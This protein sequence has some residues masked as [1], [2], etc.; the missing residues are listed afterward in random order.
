VIWNANR[1]ASG[2]YFVTITA[3]EYVGTQKMMLIK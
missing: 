3:D 2:M 1:H